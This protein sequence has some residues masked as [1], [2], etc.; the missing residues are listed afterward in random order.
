MLGSALAVS[1]PIIWIAIHHF[2][3]YIGPINGKL[4]DGISGHGSLMSLNMGLL[5]LADQAWQGMLVYTST[6]PHNWYE[7]GVPILRTLQAGLFMIGIALLVVRWK[8]SRVQMIFL[9]LLAFGAIGGL[10][11]NTPSSQRYPAV[12]PVLALV[13]GF[14]MNELATIGKKQLPWLGKW[15]AVILLVLAALLAADDARF[16]F[17]DYT[18]ASVFRDFGGQRYYQIAKDL[19]NEPAGKQV[20]CFFAP[21]KSDTVAAL[22]FLDPQIKATSIDASWEESGQTLAPGELATFVIYQE[23]KKDL[24]DIQS[25]YPGG[26]LLTRL[27][28]NGNPWYWIY[29]FPGKEHDE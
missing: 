6:A 1:M 13:V 11:E 5:K 12:V 23:H 7:P 29:R 28:A 19:Q 20:F 4:M 14:G 16:Y 27:D 3:D 9:W 25:L 24:A 17:Q 21:Y 8:E 18:P 26:E 10:S 2:Q 22:P 15:A